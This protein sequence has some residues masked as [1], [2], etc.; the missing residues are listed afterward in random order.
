MRNGG[1]SMSDKYYLNTNVIHFD[2]LLWNIETGQVF[3]LPLEEKLTSNE[4]EIITDSELLNEL[5]EKQLIIDQKAR[6][7][8]IDRGILNF[9]SLSLQKFNEL[10]NIDV[11]IVGV[12]YDLGC[13]TLPGSRYGPETMRRN[14]LV[15]HWEEVNNAVSGF[16]DY[17]LEANR[18]NGKLIFD[19]GNIGTPYELNIDKENSLNSIE[20]FS[21]FLSSKDGIPIFL[22]G[23]HSITYPIVKGLKHERINIIIFDAHSDESFEVC[24]DINE[25]RHN[26]VVTYLSSLEKV[27]KIYQVGLRDLHRSYQSEKVEI[28]KENNI[29]N[30]LSTFPKNEKYYISIDVD[31]LDPSILPNTGSLLPVGWTDREIINV[32]RVLTKEMKI[33]GVDIVELLSD[34]IH[35]S[36][37]GIIISNILLNLIAMVKGGMD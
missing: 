20:F 9:P 35:D 16:Y 3:E 22:G 4:G 12:P 30:I 23:D 32:L 34:S 13:V 10:E 11:S 2:N 19:I 6:S 26:N 1:L 18:I 14:S 31:V 37:S 7:E 33:I 21:T 28:V 24:E 15:I 8:E 36:K 5:I 29:K 25:L 17:S 27:N